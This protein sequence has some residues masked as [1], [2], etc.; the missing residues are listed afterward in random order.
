M[1]L[2]RPFCTLSRHN[3]ASANTLRF[4]YQERAKSEMATATRLNP[5]KPPPKVSPV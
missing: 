1:Q 3:L 5:Q 2:T 4:V